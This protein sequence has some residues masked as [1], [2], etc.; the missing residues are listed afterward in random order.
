VAFF[1]STPGM[2]NNSVSRQL[3][4]TNRTQTT[5][6]ST[7]FML[8]HHSSNHVL[9]LMILIDNRAISCHISQHFAHRVIYPVP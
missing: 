3:P 9:S 4:C 5:T 8:T 2:D 7:S 1:S 6:R